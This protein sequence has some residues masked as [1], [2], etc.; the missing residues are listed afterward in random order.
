[1][2]IKA[3]A[4]VTS[5]SIDVMPAVSDGHLMNLIGGENFCN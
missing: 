4:T 3:S 5:F 2:L 1:M